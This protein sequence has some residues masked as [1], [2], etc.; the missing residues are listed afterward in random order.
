MNIPMIAPLETQAAVARPGHVFVVCPRCNQSCYLICLNCAKADG[1]A[2]TERGAQCSCGSLIESVE[3]SCEASIYRVGFS[4]TTENE[5]LRE[6]AVTHDVAKMRSE[7]KKARTPGFNW[8]GATLGLAIP[9]YLLFGM[10]GVVGLVILMMVFWT[11]VGLAR[12]AGVIGKLAMSLV[13]QTESSDGVQ[14]ERL[15]ANPSSGPIAGGE[16]QESGPTGLLVVARPFRWS[17]GTIKFRVVVDGKDVGIL[18]NGKAVTASLSVG[19]HSVLAAPTSSWGGSPAP[20]LSVTIAE[21]QTTTL[22]LETGLW[23]PRLKLVND[24]ASTVDLVASQ[25]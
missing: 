19:E 12:G 7:L 18:A 6:T 16:Q 1:L 14:G 13:P 15:E 9:A 3:C 5:N 22:R 25:V 23:G 20:P 24:H 10:A 2:L 8:I 4:T 11:I 17:S 21:G